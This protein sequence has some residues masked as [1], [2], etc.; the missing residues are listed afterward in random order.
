MKRILAK[1]D[2]A[3]FYFKESEAES[4]AAKMDSLVRGI[5]KRRFEMIADLL[6]K[7]IG[8]YQPE[9]IKA[10]LDYSNTGKEEFFEFKGARV[11]TI[12]P[13]CNDEGVRIGERFV[14]ATREQVEAQL[15][16]M[17]KR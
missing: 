1:F 7:S 2:D 5:Q 6:S 17:G 12:T 10:R 13:Q 3:K 9:E 15:W 14:S 16:Q 8:H 11:L 4:L